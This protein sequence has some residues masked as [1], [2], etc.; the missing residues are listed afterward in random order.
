MNLNNN[1]SLI[2][3]NNTILYE[4]LDGC[5]FMDVAMGMDVR[6]LIREDEDEQD[7]SALK[8]TRIESNEMSGFV[9]RVTK[10]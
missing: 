2:L 6:C 3:F 9:S 7:A 8:V 4:S 5:L 1:S 10:K